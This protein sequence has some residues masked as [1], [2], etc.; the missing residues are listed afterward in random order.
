MLLLAG[1]PALSPFR[2]ERLLESVQAQVPAVQAVT[3]R[4]VRNNFV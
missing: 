3:T 2:L 1:S 4:Y